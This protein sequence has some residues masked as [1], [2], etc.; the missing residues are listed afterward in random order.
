MRGDSQTS[1][2]QIFPEEHR[3]NERKVQQPNCPRR[4]CNEVS[5]ANTQLHM[6]MYMEH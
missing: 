6:Y 3:M 5:V 2:V 1:P 4:A